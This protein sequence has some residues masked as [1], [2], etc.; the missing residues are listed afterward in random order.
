MSAPSRVFTDFL[1]RCSETFLFLSPLLRKWRGQRQGNQD[2]NTPQEIDQEPLPFEMA[3]NLFGLFDEAED[4]YE[5]GC[6]DQ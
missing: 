1:I 6:K 3:V 5:K 2:K 4:K